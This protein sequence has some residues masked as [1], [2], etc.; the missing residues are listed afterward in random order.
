MGA[1]LRRA[2]AATARTRLTDR[3]K[4]VL[5]VMGDTWMTADQIAEATGIKGYSPREMVSR[6]A[7]E[8]ARQFVL[9]K[10]GTRSAPTWRRATNAS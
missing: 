4:T 9:E 2:F 7:N 5:A 3:Q 1:G 8:L 6:T 10:G